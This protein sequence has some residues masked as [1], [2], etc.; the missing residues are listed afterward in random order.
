MRNL[1]TSTQRDVKDKPTDNDKGKKQEEHLDTIL[2]LLV[3]RNLTTS[4]QRDIKDKPID[5]SKGKTHE[6]HPDTQYEI[7][8]D[9]QLAIH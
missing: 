1:T 2:F 7:C 8:K 3:V 6:E 9:K 5:N 4:T